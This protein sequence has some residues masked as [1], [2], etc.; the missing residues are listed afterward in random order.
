MKKAKF[1]ETLY[2]KASASSA[3][4]NLLLN[5]GFRDALKEVFIRRN[6][7]KWFYKKPIL[8]ILPR[9][10]SCYFLH[11]FR[12]LQSIWRHLLFLSTHLLVCKE[13]APAF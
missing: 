8:F 7:E 5:I 12:T 9:Q 2:I 10:L 13:C 1:S 6:F 11:C 4:Q 3:W